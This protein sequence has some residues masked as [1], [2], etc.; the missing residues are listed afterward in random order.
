MNSKNEISEETI[1]AITDTA[2]QLIDKKGHFVHIENW[3]VKIVIETLLLF[4]E[5]IKISKNGTKTKA[6]KEKIDV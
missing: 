2:N 3:Q 6:S 4:G 1:K 5:A